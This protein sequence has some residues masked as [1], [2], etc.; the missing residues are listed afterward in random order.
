MSTVDTTGVQQPAGTSP[1][2]PAARLH[3]L[4]AGSWVAP[5]LAAV[6]RLGIAD[7]LA[8]GPKASGEL[9]VATGIDGRALHRVLRALASL[10]VFVEVDDGR[11]ALT[12]MAESLRSGVPGSLRNRAMMGGAPFERAAWTDIGHSLETG[13]PAFDHV[14]GTGFFDYLEQH[15]DAAGVF[16]EMMTGLTSQKSAAILRTYDF[17][18]VK[19][20]VDVG[21]GHGTLMARALA[22]N[23]GMQGVIFDQPTVVEGALGELEAAAVADRCRLVG[24]DFFASV[25]AGGDVYLL[26]AVLHNWDD[27]QAV[28]ILRTCRAAM[29]SDSRLIVVE[30]MIPPGNGPDLGKLV[31]LQML[32]LFGGRE[33]TEREFR[34]LFAEAGFELAGSRAMPFAGTIIEGTPV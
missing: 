4:L 9:A 21:G 12:P 15:P 1:R 25:P 8:D 31:D 30:W 14:F 16:N 10:E 5:T 3:D 26:V 7:L 34:E 24:G 11:F 32:V 33:R 2:P 28:A 13:E 19:T 29:S 18:G 6:A 22:T 20:L 23:P 27:D 17:S